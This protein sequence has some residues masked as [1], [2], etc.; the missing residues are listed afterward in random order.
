MRTECNCISYNRP[1]LGGTEAETVLRVPDNLAAQI[2][3]ETVCVDP[4]IADTIKA[5]WAAGIPTLGCCCGHNGKLPRT[6]VVNEAYGAKA[7][8]FLAGRGETMQV[9]AW[10]L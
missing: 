3:R 5:M 7:K 8:D 2:G 4:C 1:E 6:V 9:M 10:R